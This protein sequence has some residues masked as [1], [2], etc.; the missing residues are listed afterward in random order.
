MLLQLEMLLRYRL[1]SPLAMLPQLAM[2]TLALIGLH[3]C[4]SASFLLAAAAAV[5]L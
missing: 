5:L 3:R 2:L 1:W 4:D